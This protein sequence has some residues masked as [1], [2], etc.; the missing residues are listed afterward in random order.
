MYLFSQGTAGGCGSRREGDTKD[1]PDT[2]NLLK[3]YRIF[4]QKNDTLVKMAEIPDFSQSF[5]FI[6]LFISGSRA[7]PPATKGEKS[8]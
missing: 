8:S 3:K 2:W 5:I 4:P 6:Y 1:G 7:Y